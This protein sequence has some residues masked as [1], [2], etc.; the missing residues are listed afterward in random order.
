MPADQLEIAFASWVTDHFAPEIEGYC[1]ILLNRVD[2]IFEDVD[3]EARRAMDEF[4]KSAAA[5]ARDDD[6]DDVV[7]AAYEH[8]QQ[9]AQQFFEM[10]AVFL[11]TGV[12]GLF[13][14]FERQ[15]YLHINKELKDWLNKPI[16]LWRDLED[17]IPHFDHKSRQDAQCTDFIGAFNDPDLQEL[18]LVANTVKHGGDGS[19]YQQLVKNQA[20]VVSGARLEADYAAGAHTILGVDISVQRDDVE[21]YRDSVLRFWRL[22]GTFW[23]PRSAFK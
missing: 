6:Y 15:L 23:A 5:H 11:A 8:A 16:A 22:N 19:S 21:R 2:P 7:D 13:H 20:I 17:L 18:R 3:G 1:N 14:L 10:R 12:S 9:T 4:I